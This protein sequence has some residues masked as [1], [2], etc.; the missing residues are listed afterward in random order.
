MKIF[1]DGEII[2][3]FQ[4]DM[5]YAVKNLSDNE[6][7]FG[8]GKCEYDEESNSYDTIP[9]VSREMVDELQEQL[10]ET[11]AE[12][13]TLKS[14]GDAKKE[15]ILESK[16]AVVKGTEITGTMPNKG[17]LSQ[18]LTAG[19]SLTLAPGYYSGGTITANTLASQTA[20]TAT[21]AS[22]L[23]GK[24]AWVNGT[25][26]T[27]TAA[28][29]S[30]TEY[31]MYTYKQKK[32]FTRKIEKLVVYW[33]GAGDRPITYYDDAFITVG[34]G[35]GGP[36]FYGA[37]IFTDGRTAIARVENGTG[38]LLTY[39]DYSFTCTGGSAYTQNYY[40]VKFKD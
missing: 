9:L 14:K 31:G 17:T 11:K 24:T 30:N 3:C 16:K 7:T 39:D 20:A 2:A 21:A 22:I 13:N 28:A 40:I 23:N 33:T 27:G 38:G 35:T 6:L 4:R 10:D 15:E 12:L 25:Q 36:L 29:G 32:T 18:S 37:F 5:W 1:N 8:E 26:V 19:A 34:P